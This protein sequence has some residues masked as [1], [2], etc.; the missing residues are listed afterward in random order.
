MSR[1]P[2]LAKS[3]SARTL[4]GAAKP[5]SEGRG[6][7]RLLESI[8][9][10]DRVLRAGACVSLTRLAEELEASP[11][12][13]QR[14]LETLRDRLNA[15]VIY[16]RGARG[17][18]YARD[19]VAIPAAHLSEGE[20]V[21]L[22]VA[23]PVLARYRG[24]PLEADFRSA[25]DKITASLPERVRSRYSALPDRVSAKAALPAEDNTARFRALLAAVLEER[26]VALSYYSAHRDAVS[27][28]L[29]D[30]YAIH[31]AEGSWYLIGHC[32]QRQRILTFHIGR[33]REL[34]VTDSYFE[35]PGDF[36][37]DR[38]LA[39]AFGIFLDPSGT[40]QLETI[41]LRCDPFAARYVR[42]TVW[43][44]SQTIRELSDGAIDLTLRIA[45]TVEIERFVLSWGEHVHVVSPPNLRRK[46]AARLREASRRYAARGQARRARNERRTPDDTLPLG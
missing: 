37:V 43:H 26:T 13:V 34:R 6:T 33:I 20:L 7:R 9:H 44:P 21:A 46:V 45:G 39:S 16:D 14:Y 29:V 42:E 35:R 25:F 3:G 15:P 17:Y 32:H 31:N 41:V 30:P 24:T 8:L 18:R 36:A 2:Y 10:I 23:E 27:E 19:S 40:A 11:R 4:R 5:A 12:T 38:F 28:R 1:A 22:Y